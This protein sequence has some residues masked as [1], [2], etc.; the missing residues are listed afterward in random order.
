MKVCSRGTF[1][2]ALL[3]TNFSFPFS[4]GSYCSGA[5]CSGAAHCQGS[6]SPFGCCNGGLLALT[7]AA[8]EGLTVGT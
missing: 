6:C 1:I 3:E 8:E 2:V 4:S 5:S 7:K